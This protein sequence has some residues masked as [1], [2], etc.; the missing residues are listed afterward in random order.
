MSQHIASLQ[1]TCGDAPFEIKSY[2]RNHEWDFGHDVIVPA[3]AAANFTGDETR[4]DPEQAF[5][6]SLSS[7][8]M[9]TFLAIASLKKRTVESY[10]DRAI[11]HLE[12]NSDGHMVI[13]RVDLH[14][15]VVFADGQAPDAETLKQMHHKA[16]TRCFLANS[17]KCEIVTHLD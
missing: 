12:K 1:W 4:A 5:V 17:V 11:G 10:C 2:S 14:P 9:L 16:H 15:V 7:C 6:A 13:T 8:H 3:S